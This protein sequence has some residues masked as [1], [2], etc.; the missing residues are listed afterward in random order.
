MHPNKTGESKV[1]MVVVSKYY[2]QKFKA[3]AYFFII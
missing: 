2:N 1:N 3:C